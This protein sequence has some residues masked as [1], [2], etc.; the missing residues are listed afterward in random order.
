MTYEA[1]ITP[2]AQVFLEKMSPGSAPETA[3][4]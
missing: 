2:V 3:T 4:T 1:K